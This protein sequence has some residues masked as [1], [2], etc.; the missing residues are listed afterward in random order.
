MQEKYL[1]GSY[2]SGCAGCSVSTTVIT[3]SV[4]RTDNAIVRVSMVTD[5]CRLRNQELPLAFTSGG[6]NLHTHTHRN[7]HTH[8]HKHNTQRHTQ[9]HTTQRHTHTH[10]CTHTHTQAQTHTHTQTDTHTHTHTHTHTRNTWNKEDKKNHAT[11]RSRDKAQTQLGSVS[12]ILIVAQKALNEDMT[13]EYQSNSDETDS[14]TSSRC[15]ETDDLPRVRQPAEGTPTCRGYAN[16]PRV[17]QPAEGTL[18]CRGYANLPR[19]RQPAEGMPT[20][21]G[22]ANLP[23]V[24]QPAEGT[25]TNWSGS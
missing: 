9:T 7:T 8:K 4:A 1:H 14:A 5:R 2:T 19:V 13:F 22:Y 20:C 3:A 15:G 11:N 25:P 21:R 12:H 23:R 16:L 10:A 17:R 24:R 6:F 18:T